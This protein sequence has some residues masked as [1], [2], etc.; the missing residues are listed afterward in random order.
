MKW[1][2]L[3]IGIVL[4]IAVLV[5]AI[6]Y[7]MPGTSGMGAPTVSTS[8]EIITS[9]GSLPYADKE[10]EFT[11]LHPVTVPPVT[12]GFE[13]F[14]PV[15]AEPVVGFHFPQSLYQ[16]TNL[17]DAGVFIGASP[18]MNKVNACL[19]TG[20]QEKSLGTKNINGVNFQVFASSGV[21]A[22]NIYDEVSYRTVRSGT[23]YEIV[24]LLHSG[25]IGNYPAGSVKQYDH[26]AFRAMLDTMVGTFAFT[27]AEGSGVEGKVTTTCATDA[28]DTACAPQV[29]TI[30]A[31][32]G[33]SAV[34]LFKTAVDG[35]FR[36]MLPPGQ[37]ELRVD[38]ASST[39][40]A[41]VGVVITDKNFVTTDISCEAGVQ[42]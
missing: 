19:S 39:H 36:S 33:V 4:V 7:G 8:T 12:T 10:Y 11:I 20:E 25:N 30:E 23:C 6:S 21:G 32:Q 22:G 34:G 42:E 35:T 14:L 24:E 28:S 18:E 1:P 37:Y 5:F 29:R 41:S 40:C 9:V 2:V 3:F 27:A 31:Y 38:T 13:G 16:G 26:D 15:T 17:V